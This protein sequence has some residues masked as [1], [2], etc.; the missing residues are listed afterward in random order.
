MCATN[1]TSATQTRFA[2]SIAVL[3]FAGL[4]YQSKSETGNG[5]TNAAVASP[6]ALHFLEDDG[7]GV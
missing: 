3:T 5:T 7:G 4:R 2:I 6:A 1:L